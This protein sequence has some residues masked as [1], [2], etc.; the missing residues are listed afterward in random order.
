[1]NQKPKVNSP[2]E[3]LVVIAGALA[4]CVVSLGFWGGAIAAFAGCTMS[5]FVLALLF[6]IN[7]AFLAKSIIKVKSHSM[8]SLV[9]WCLPLVVLAKRLHEVY[10][11]ANP[12]LP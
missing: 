4:S 3:A 11:A 1:M 5:P 9:C 6:T 10:L 7:L 12:L 2:E 8:F